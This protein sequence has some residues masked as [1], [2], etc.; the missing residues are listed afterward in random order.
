MEDYSL[1]LN[2]VEKKISDSFVEFEVTLKKQKEEYQLI[3]NRIRNEM[4]TLKSE[5]M[6]NEQQRSKVGRI[7]AS[8]R[9]ILN[10]GGTLF[11]TTRQTLTKQ[12][13]SMLN[14]MFNGSNED[15]V[16]PDSKGHYFIDRDPEHFQTILNYLRTDQLILPESKIER[17]KLELEL[18]F[19]CIK[20]EE[21]ILTTAIDSSIIVNEKEF[22]SIRNFL[23]QKNPS[24]KLLY[25]ATKLG[26][27]NCNKIINTSKQQ[28]RLYLFKTQ[29]TVFGGYS[30][31]DES[32]APLNSYYRDDQAFIFT[33][34][35][36]LNTPPEKYIC[37]VPSNSKYKWPNNCIDFGGGG[38]IQINMDTK[39][40]HTNFPYHYE[41]N[42][43]SSYI[44][45]KAFLGGCNNFTVTE[46]EIFIIND[47]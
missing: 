19:Y 43:F 46:V 10:I 14:V 18:D 27:E 20:T 1:L 38:D 32:D 23:P 22:N 11:E 9:I 13:N 42:R 26:F 39:Q 17:T 37:K 47:K 24:F 45:G 4:E 8:Q 41:C 30:T 36:L 44:E 34:K 6:I 33:L 12:P 15:I 28:P 2:S 29:S 21:K 3:I 16:K 7:A 35:N 25:R 40:G 5:R 31:V